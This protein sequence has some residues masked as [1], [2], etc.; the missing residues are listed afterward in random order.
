MLFSTFIAFLKT[1]VA[2]PVARRSVSLI[3]LIRHWGGPGLF[4]LAILD[5]LPFPTFGGP[6]ILTAILAARHH[7]PWYYYALMSTV[8][9]VIG[10]YI[11]YRT[12]R[13]AGASYLSKKFG[14]R[15][16]NK[17]LAQFERWGA[18]GLLFSTAV[19]VPFP[20]SAFFAAAG[21]VNYP[22]RR[23]IGVVA[24]GRAVRYSVIA[25]LAE[26][27]GRHFIRVLRHPQQYLGWFVLI[28]CI[29]L[30]MILAAIWLKKQ[31]ELTDQNATAVHEG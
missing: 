23:F 25:F 22:R 11:T 21:V 6:D 2:R 15:R 26:R 1:V 12:A 16:V 8:G 5:G 29:A 7:E 13:G 14:E 4:V 31:M 17:L 27:Y 10:A 24:A 18:G 3:V 30:V 20:T 19:P 28:V 9:A